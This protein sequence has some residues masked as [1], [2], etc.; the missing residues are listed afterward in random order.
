MGCPMS[1]TCARCFT[2][3]CTVDWSALHVVKSPC[4]RYRYD[5]YT[6]WHMEK[7]SICN[8]ISSLCSEQ[9]QF[10]ESEVQSR[11]LACKNLN[12]TSEHPIEY[13]LDADSNNLPLGKNTALNV[14][15]DWIV[16]LRI[17]KSHEQSDVGNVKE[18]EMD[19]YCSNRNWQYVFCI[20]SAEYSGWS[21][22]YLERVCVERR[23]LNSWRVWNLAA[24]N[25]LKSLCWLVWKW[26]HD[27]LINRFVQHSACP[28]SSLRYDPT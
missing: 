1:K 8:K 6:S 27:N 7:W 13:L 5:A 25:R 2:W 3:C 12:L 9:V 26:T 18:E 20:F 4:K 21:L 17:T 19:G 16:L 11:G 28:F 23:N 22:E 15:L 14:I 24:L 10:W